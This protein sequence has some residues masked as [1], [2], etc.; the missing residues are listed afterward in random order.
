MHFCCL[1]RGRL[2]NPRRMDMFNKKKLTAAVQEAEHLVQELW[3][4]ELENKKLDDK[5]ECY[6]G[7]YVVEA[8]ER[9]RL[10]CHLAMLRDMLEEQKRW[11][12]GKPYE[13]SEIL[14]VILSTSGIWWKQINEW[15]KLAR[16]PTKPARNPSCI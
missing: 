5:A 12:R 7:K 2:L 16:N 11:P 10:D 6:L 3:A 4:M 1:D 8:E 9:R 14:N 15:K 13:L